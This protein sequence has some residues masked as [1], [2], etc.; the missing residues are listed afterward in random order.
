MKRAAIMLLAAVVSFV[1]YALVIRRTPVLFHFP[2]SCACTDY[3]EEVKGFTVLNPFRDRSPERAASVFL[4]ELSNGRCP[5]GS[6]PQIVSDFCQHV[7]P[8]EKF[9]YFEWRLRNRVD[10]P[11][12]TTMYYSFRRVKDEPKFDGEGFVGLIEDNG[13]WK[14]SGFDV[15]W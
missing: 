2:G 12:Q 6:T 15:I 11:H 10:Q 7:R 8:G 5:T 4:T 3:S 1:F 9:P 14:P 13:T